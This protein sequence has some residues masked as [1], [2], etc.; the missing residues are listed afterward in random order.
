MP[1]ILPLEQ[2]NTWLAPDSNLEAVRSLLTSY[3]SEEFDFHP[4]SKEVNS[5]KNNHPKILQRL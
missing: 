5:P 1:V 4:V 3:P 2:Y